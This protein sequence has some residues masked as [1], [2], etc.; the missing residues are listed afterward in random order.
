MTQ[1]KKILDYMYAGNKLTPLEALN[2]FGCFRLASV[3]H[4]AK[5]K[6]HN[7]K[8][9]MVSSN[10]KHFAEYSIEIF[11]NKNGQLELI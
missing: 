9:R 7:I 1:E 5:K 2:K 8:S 4:S 10:N 6:G 3:I 11:V